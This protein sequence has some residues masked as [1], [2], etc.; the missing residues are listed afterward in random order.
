MIIKFSR[1]Y[2]QRSLPFEINVPFEIEVM[3]MKENLLLGLIVNVL[4]RICSFWHSV[5]ESDH[6]QF[7]TSMLLHMFSSRCLSNDNFE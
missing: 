7:K 2:V 1:Y 3:N 4:M 5:I 6:L